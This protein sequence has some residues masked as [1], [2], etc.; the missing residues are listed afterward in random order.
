MNASTRTGRLANALIRI[1]AGDVA[2]RLY[3]YGL[4]LR[5]GEATPADGLALP[6]P[7]LRVLTAG[8]PDAH[9]FLHLGERAA[10]EFLRLAT[11]HGAPLG[12]ADAVLE[13]GCGCGRVAR[14]VSARTPG[15]FHGC[16]INP[17]LVRW[18]REHLRGEYRVTDQTPPLP[19]DGE[20][21]A[22]VYALSVFTHM[23][24]APARAWLAD[25]AR[26]TRLGGLALLTFHDEHGPGAETLQPELGRDGFRIRYRAREGSNLHTGYFTHEGFAARAVPA[27]RWLHGVKSTDSSMGQ[28]IAVLQRV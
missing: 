10:D 14:Y 28:A 8:D 23:R 7:Y 20:S 25:L 22:L 26:V 21:F 4:A 15:P 19:Y 6:P 13:F 16:D 27:W 1:G 2:F 11:E 24:D 17:K 5:G 18:C 3:Q 12:D 9:G